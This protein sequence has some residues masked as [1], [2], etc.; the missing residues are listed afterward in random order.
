[1]THT[2]RQALQYHNQLTGLGPTQHQMNQLTA[3]LG[4]L[5]GLKGILGP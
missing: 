4:G 5:A 2:N 3:G 1:M